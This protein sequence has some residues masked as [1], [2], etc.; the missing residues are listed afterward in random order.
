MVQ[1]AT[2]G[3]AIAASP[4]SILAYIGEKF[5][6]WSDPR[7]LDMD[8]LLSTATIYYL[9]SCFQTS[10]MIYQQA[11]EKR[12]WLSDYA[13]WGRIK[14]LIAYSSFVRQLDLRNITRCWLNDH[15]CHR[16]AIRD[17]V[18]QSPF[19]KAT[20]I[21]RQPQLATEVVDREMWSSCAV[22][23]CVVPHH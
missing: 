22:Q 4:L 15:L 23:E 17:K 18:R 21:L 5:L 2:I 13:V 6:A 12:A 3:Y 11:R 19:K 14:S 20:S 1:P 8:D 10:V 7:F 9:T 16:T